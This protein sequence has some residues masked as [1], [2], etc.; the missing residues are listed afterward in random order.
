VRP[1]AITT[2]VPQDRLF[3]PRSGGD[4]AGAGLG[5]V[6][7]E[8][9]VVLRLDG[10]VVVGGDADRRLLPALEGAVLGL[11]VVVGDGEGGEGV[12]RLAADLVAGADADLVEFVQD[13]ELGDRQLV[14]AVEHDGGAQ[15]GQVEPAGAAGTAG[16]GAEFVAALAQMLAVGVVQLRGE[17]AAADAGGVGLG[18]ADHGVDVLRGHAEAGADAAYDGVRGGHERVRAVVDVEHH[19]LR[20]FEHDPFAGPDVLVDPDGTVGDARRQD[21]AE[22]Q[23]V[24][25]ELRG[26]ER[27]RVVDA[28]EHGVALDAGELDLLFQDHRIEE[29]GDADA[30]AADL[31]FIGRPDSTPG[32]PDLS[33][34]GRGLAG[35]V[36]RLVVGEDA[37]CGVADEQVLLDDHA[38]GAQVPD[39]LEQ[40]GGV[41]DHAVA[42]EAELVGMDD[43]GG[44]E[45]E[46]EVLVGELDRVA[47]VVPALVPRHHV[48]C[49]AE[50]VDDLPFS[51]VPPLR[52]EDGNVLSLVSHGRGGA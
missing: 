20:A 38:G 49:L 36:Q 22:A 6:L 16:H 34:A 30:V 26:I 2:P 1:C 32:R 4:D 15:D 24:V 47:G 8:P 9:D 10:E 37:V 5:L 50:Q 44:D 31:G 11:V 42:E 45:P 25:V 46:G 29:V 52:A 21:L 3:A 39:L 41:D 43:A 14:E 28:G 17:G 33:L 19:P 35:Q 12:P 18:H 13:V 51:L 23:V 40:R 48:E 7:D 27:L